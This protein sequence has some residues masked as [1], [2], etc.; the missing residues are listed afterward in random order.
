[1]G[2][3]YSEN[4]TSTADAHILKNVYCT[5]QALKDKHT[6]LVRQYFNAIYP[7]YTVHVHVHVV[8]N[9]Q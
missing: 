7:A 3:K 5:V 6:F 1:M 9:G 2:G 8:Y 4:I